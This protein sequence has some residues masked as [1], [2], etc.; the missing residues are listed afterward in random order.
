MT[1][2]GPSKLCVAR[3]RLSTAQLA[4]S[5]A[6]LLALCVPLAL[7]SATAAQA[8]PRAS[9][10]TRSEAGARDAAAKAYDRGTAAYLRS[11]YVRAAGWFE[12]A[13]RLLPSAPA[14]IQATRAYTKAQKLPRALTLALRLEEQYPD[15]ERAQSLATELL[16]QHSREYVHVIVECG[17]C[18]LDLDGKLQE[19]SE[20]FIEPGQDREITAIFPD[21]EQSETVSGLAA[22][23]LTV[24]FAGPAPRQHGPLDRDIPNATG[25]RA[26]APRGSGNMAE[27]SGGLSPVLVYV[28]AVVSVGLGVG[29]AVSGLSAVKRGESF[30]NAVADF[31]AAGCDVDG[32]RL[33]PCAKLDSRVSER[34]DNA[35]GAEQRTNILL[36]AAIGAGVVTL[37]LALLADW[38][39]DTSEPQGR[40]SARRMWLGA[41]PTADGG[42]ATIGGAF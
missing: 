30:D 19:S 23:Q 40:S 27:E 15:D 17:D 12:T 9:A 18:R 7:S 20:F 24:G 11:D 13:H 42:L 14:L 35:S 2:A 31:E 3:S 37:A 41:A 16:G 10:E 1:V 29:T 5:T 32:A 6:W 39:G 34:F 25:S 36:G 33:E 26:M 8:A 28:G 38:D 4:R 21:G 22:Q